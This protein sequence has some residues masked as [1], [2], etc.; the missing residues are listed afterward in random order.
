[1]SWNPCWA[2]IKDW[3]GQILFGTEIWCKQ[4]RMMYQNPSTEVYGL[5]HALFTWLS[6][7]LTFTVDQCQ[8]RQNKMQRYAGSCWRSY[9]RQWETTTLTVHTWRNPL[10][11]QN[12]L[13]A[14]PFKSVQSVAIVK[15][16]LSEGLRFGK[17]CLRWWWDY[18]CAPTSILGYY[19]SPPESPRKHIAF[20]QLVIH[21]MSTLGIYMQITPIFEKST[22]NHRM[23][24][25]MDWMVMLR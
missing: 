9:D 21:I 24:H 8:L 22:F 6:L 18:I 12:D 10:G 16:N 20:I 14:Q 19:E 1:M 5:V 25:F 7:I 4:T 11:L 23:W 17:P 13:L 15:F 2:Q 3:P